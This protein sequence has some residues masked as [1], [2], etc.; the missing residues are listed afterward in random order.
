MVTWDILMCDALPNPL[1]E[2][3]KGLQNICFYKL[4]SSVGQFLSCDP[5]FIIL[6]LKYSA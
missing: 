5:E 6:L 1:V 3:V 4:P 2:S